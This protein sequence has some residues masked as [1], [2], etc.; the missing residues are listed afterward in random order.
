MK[1]GRSAR[2]PHP[3]ES[4]EEHCIAYA[5]LQEARPKGLQP[6]WIDRYKYWEVAQEWFIDLAD[7]ILGKYPKLYIIPPYREQEKC[8]SRC[9]NAQGHKCQYLCMSANHGAGGPCAG[10]FKVLD[11]FATR[12]GE[13]H[14]ACR[15]ME[16]T[17]AR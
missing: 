10:W 14:L 2:H 7:Y 9:M 11:T 1:T 4:F 6:E 15:L 16:R 8:A 17:S 12:S 5:L 3:G 13:S